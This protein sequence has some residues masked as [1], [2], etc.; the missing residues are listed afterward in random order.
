MSTRLATQR[1]F[2]ISTS[3]VV[4]AASVDASQIESKN[5]A[6]TT[7]GELLTVV[8]Q[9]TPSPPTSHAEEFEFCTEDGVV[10]AATLEDV[11]TQ[12]CQILQKKLSDGLDDDTTTTTDQLEVIR[13]VLP[14]DTSD[15]SQDAH[16]HAHVHAV[17]SVSSS[18]AGATVTTNSTAT[19]HTLPSLSAIKSDVDLAQQVANGQLTVV[20]ATE[21]DEG[22]PF[23][24]VTGLGTAPVTTRAG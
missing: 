24:T 20:Q 19:I 1:Q 8:E 2:I 16:L 5:V 14:M 17:N 6:K 22:T 12:N 15:S 13:V 11:M 23:I 4:D 21:D 9:R 18:D 10:V 3:A 7:G